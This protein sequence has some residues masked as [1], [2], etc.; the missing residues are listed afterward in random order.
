MSFTNSGLVCAENDLWINKFEGG[1]LLELLE[2]GGG[3]RDTTGVRGGANGRHRGG[4]GVRGAGVRG[5]GD[6]N[7]ND[8]GVSTGAGRGTGA[9]VTGIKG[10]AKG[11]C[12]GDADASSG[13]GLFL[14]GSFLLGALSGCIRVADLRRGLAMDEALTTVNLVYCTGGCERATG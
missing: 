4:A 6:A 12:R 8:V 5:G 2:R 11:S 7:T 13:G 1:R 10:G 14:T 9:E 3:G